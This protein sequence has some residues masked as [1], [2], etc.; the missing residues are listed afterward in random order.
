MKIQIPKKMGHIW[1]GNKPVPNE[2]INTWKEHHKNWEYTSYD[3]DFYASFDF[4]TRHL[5]DRYLGLEMYAG[6]SDLMRYEI[7][8]HFGGFIPEAD[9]ICYHNT[10]ELFSKECA[11]TVYEN[12][13]LR[14][15]LVSPI[16]AC[17]P[18]NK[19][20]GY[21]ID[22][23]LKLSPDN[24]G[25][26]WKT[27]GNLFV[28][29]MIEKYQPDIVVF[30]SHYFIPIHF[31]GFVYPGT[32]KIYAKQLFGSTRDVY[33]QNSKLKWFKR[34]LNKFKTRK[35][36]MEKQKHMD[37]FHKNNE[38]NNNKLFNHNFNQN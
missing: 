16:Y 12:E 21:L 17:E 7:L 32:D 27:T 1:I 11:Y 33:P 2:W 19:F 4:K 23:L 22:E 6:A 3:N 9:S 20:V 28:A 10:D 37:V 35:K 13:F 5:I 31:D 36:R 29:R 26:A 30:P 25:D 14:G 15:K 18:Q 34:K 8:Y 38:E 24:L